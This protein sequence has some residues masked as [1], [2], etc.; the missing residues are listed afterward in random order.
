L[1]P[2]GSLCYGRAA[3]VETVLWPLGALIISFLVSLGIGRLG[4]RSWRDTEGR[5][6]T[7]RNAALYPHRTTSHACIGCLP[8]IAGLTDY[9]VR[10]HWVSAF[11]AAYLGAVA[12]SYP[13]DHYFFPDLKPTL[14]LR[15]V[16][17]TIISELL[18]YVVLA[19]GMFVMPATFSLGAMGIAG[20]T[21]AAILALE[22]G[23][24]QQ[25][26]R[27]LGIL[28]PADG[29]ILDRVATVS[30]KRQVPVRRVWRLVGV[31][32]QA[33][34]YTLAGSLAFTDP[35]IREMPADEVEAVIAHELGHLSEPRGL[36]LLRL[37]KIFWVL[38]ILMFRP[39]E[40][41]L[42]KALAIE[43]A[44]SFIWIVR[45]S[46]RALGRKLEERADRFA[47]NE[48]DQSVAYGRAL[49]HLSRLNYMPMVMNGRSRGT[50]PHTYDRMLACGIT[51]DY[52]RPLPPPRPTL[53]V[54]LF[55]FAA[56]IAVG[57]V[58]SRG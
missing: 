22:I 44:A 24:G 37:A 20:L 56:V 45:G 36:R 5:H 42:G 12:G 54:M 19:C 6:W 8:I 16:G 57:L 50:H 51:P 14:W 10:G 46:V 33:L 55:G 13:G 28:K 1:F 52:P 27:L 38:P 2:F 15:I 18:Y 43:A 31:A 48:P 11:V 40:S 17:A 53:W 21:M 58:I 9:G 41:I 34:A 39:L 47:V 25:L 4:I 29:N 30:A 7:E 49:E 3:S 35:F 23:F 32:Y 26:M